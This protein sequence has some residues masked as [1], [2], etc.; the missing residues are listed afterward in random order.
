MIREKRVLD[1]FLINEKKPEFYDRECTIIELLSRYE[2]KLKAMI[3]SK[4][5]IDI[6]AGDFGIDEDSMQSFIDEYNKISMEGQD[7]INH[8]NNVLES[9]KELKASDT[10]GISYANNEMKARENIAMEPS[11]VESRQKA[12]MEPIIVNHL[13]YDMSKENKDL[14]EVRLSIMALEHL[15]YEGSYGPYEQQKK[16]LDELERLK[17]E[18]SNLEKENRSLVYENAELKTS[19]R[20]LKED[21]EELISENSSLKDENKNLKQQVKDVIK[22]AREYKDFVLQTIRDMP[23]IGKLVTKRIEKSD[24]ALSEGRGER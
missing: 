12:I 1:Y 22:K 9:I 17:K 3:S 8:Y 21:K 2:I 13:L 4:T 11:R 10:V 18:N 15:G 16:L 14:N 24:K 5:S 6:M 23:V 19:V 20:I 7:N